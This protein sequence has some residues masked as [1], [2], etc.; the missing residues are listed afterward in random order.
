MRAP[1]RAICLAAA[2]GCGGTEERAVRLERVAPPADPDCG[3]P[4]DARTLLV[5]ALGDFPASEGTVES[6]EVDAGAGEFN[7]AGFPAETRALEVEV[8][9]FGGALRAVGRTGEFDLEE[10]EEGSAIHVFMAPPR[11]VCPTGPPEVDRVRPLLARAGGR[12]LVA[13]GEDPDGA[14]VHLVEI[15]DPA[16]GQFSGLGTPLY[17]SDL[18]EGLAGASITTLADGRVVVA[19]GAGSAYQVFDPESGA[20]DTPRFLRQARAYHAALALGGDRLLLAGGCARLEGGGCEAGSELATSAILSVDSGELEDGPPLARIRLGGLALPDAGGRVLLVGGVASGAPVDVAE[21]IDPDGGGAGELIAAAGGAAAVLASGAVLTA[22]A[23]DG[24]PASDAGAVVAGG[25][26][27]AVDVGPARA[28]AV[29]AAL[30]GGLVLAIG[31]AEPPGLYAPARGEL[32]LLPDAGPRAGHAAIRLADGSVLLVGGLDGGGAPAGASVFRPDLLGALSGGLSVTFASDESSAPLVPRDPARA[33]VVPSAGDRPA[34]Y[35]VESSGGGD[36]PSEW[37]VVAGPVFG[38]LRLEASVSAEEG[39]VAALLWF[40]GPSDH[41]L[42]ALEPGQVA[43]L[44]RVEGGEAS[45]L[46]SC[47]GEPVAGGDLAGRSHELTVDVHGGELVAVLDDRT[48]LTCSVE[49]PATGLVGLAPLGDAA[50][51][52]IDLVSATR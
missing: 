44:V 1:V 41:A 4:A 12:V 13:G 45:A 16:T 18:A 24:A 23:P 22:F 52:T 30:E 17:G 33:R 32:D 47:E 43:R 40:A 11:G 7:L 26:A 5:R 49:P 3:A 2:L 9:G 31:G 21:R 14:P 29:L 34:H 37:A 36:L 8:L 48:V 35:R 20:F 28:G 10:V 15:Y 19:G 50:V 51:L 46:G 39:G 27:S 38:E 42:V 25:G 6:I